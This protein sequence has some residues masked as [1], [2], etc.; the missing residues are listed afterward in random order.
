MPRKIRE[1]IQ[2]IKE[3]E[4]LRNSRCR[5]RGSSKIYSRQ[6]ADG[7]S[8]ELRIGP[9]KRLCPI[10]LS[11]AVVRVVIL[12][13][14]LGVMLP[15]VSVACAE[16][17]CTREKGLSQLVLASKQ[18]CSPSTFQMDHLRTVGVGTNLTKAKTQISIYCER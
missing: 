12:L 11:V 17:T 10:H 14:S 16:T 7:L 15:F 8:N 4:F 3:A 5:D 18:M 6:I 1:L 2:G 13:V 9:F